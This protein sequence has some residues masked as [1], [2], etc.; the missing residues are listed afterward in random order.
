MISMTDR[1][2]RDLMDDPLQWV[3][4]EIESG[5][6]LRIAA[7]AAGVGATLLLVWAG[8]WGFSLLLHRIAW[9]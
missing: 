3:V 7:H 2:I 1:E 4:R 6:G 8:V 5:R 9:M